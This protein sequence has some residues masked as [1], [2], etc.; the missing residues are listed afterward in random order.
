[1][2]LPDP[3]DDEGFNLDFSDPLTRWLALAL[4]LLAWILICPVSSAQT[5]ITIENNN[6]Q[7]TEQTVLNFVTKPGVTATLSKNEIVAA[8]ESSPE[9]QKINKRHA[10]FI[11][12]VQSCEKRNWPVS[13]PICHGYALSL[14]HWFVIDHPE[15]FGPGALGDVKK[16]GG[17]VP[18]T[19]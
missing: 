19:K 7:A 14:A 11:R 15:F 9:L 18:A 4:L 1:M 8:P 6:P 12:G 3:F 2:R 13:D 16:T 10:H 5:P 17:A